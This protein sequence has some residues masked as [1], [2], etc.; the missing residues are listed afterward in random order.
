MARSYINP[1]DVRKL[2]ALID[3]VARLRGIVT[4]LGMGEQR[5]GGISAAFPQVLKVRLTQTGG[6]AGTASTPC[7]F[8]YSAFLWADTAKQTPI[9]TNVSVI[10]SGG[11]ATVG[12][13]IAA[14]FGLMIRDTNNALRLLWCDESPDAGTGCT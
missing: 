13:Y 9:A 8:L 1:A 12:A 5:G 7:T 6:S 11:R 2:N 4:Q 3:E 14:N 10:G